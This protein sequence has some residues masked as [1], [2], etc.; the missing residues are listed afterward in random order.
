M[1]LVR[2]SNFSDEEIEF[3]L[4][5]VEEHINV[6]ESRKTDNSINIQKK[7][8]WKEITILFNSNPACK[9]GR[10]ADQIINKW[11]NLKKV[12]C[13]SLIGVVERM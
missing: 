1:A 8:T 4:T 9:P 7:K 2:S 13:L 5:L 10:T 3:L 6:I 11:R 12:I